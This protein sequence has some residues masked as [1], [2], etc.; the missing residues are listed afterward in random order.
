MW[1]TK[2]DAIAFLNTGLR[3]PGLDANQVKRY[4]GYQSHPKSRVTPCTPR[5]GAASPRGSIRFGAPAACGGAGFGSRSALANSGAAARQRPSP[6]LP[7]CPF[8]PPRPIRSVIAPAAVHA[9]GS[10][11]PHALPLLPRPIT[12]PHRHTPLSSRPCL[13][14]CPIKFAQKDE[15]SHEVLNEVYLQNIFRDEYNFSRRI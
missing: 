7:V 12:R 2:H 8:V 15:R 4:P 14:R 3:W 11:H 13:V 1:P 9:G 10:G 6:R 5:T